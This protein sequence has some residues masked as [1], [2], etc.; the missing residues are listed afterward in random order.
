[1]QTGTAAFGHFYTQTL[2]RGFR[3]L[4]KKTLE[5]S[6]SVVRDVNHRVGKYGCEVSKSK[7]QA[8]ALRAQ[9][10]TAFPAVTVQIDPESFRGR[11][12]ASTLRRSLSLIFFAIG[13]LEFTIG[14]TRWAGSDC[15][16]RP[17]PA[18]WR[19]AKWWSARRQS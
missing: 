4:R 17:W 3:S 1:M 6:N 12:L 11:P 7:N 16:L 18:R 10:V 13:N 14:D 2:S 19:P 9:G 15:F 5:L 8:T